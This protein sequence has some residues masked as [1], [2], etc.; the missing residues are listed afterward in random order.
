MKVGSVFIYLALRQM[1][2]GR[3]LFALYEL[4]EEAAPL[5]DERLL[6]RI[7]KAIARAEK[8]LEFEM[9]WSTART[10]TSTKR[11]KA[12]LI[13]AK[14]DQQIGALKSLARLM[15][16]GDEG[17]EV[18]ALAGEFLQAN[19]PDG[20]AAIVQ[21]SFELQLATVDGML[22]RFRGEYRRHVEAL[23]AGPLVDR[24][25]RLNDELRQELRHHKSTTITFDQVR[26]SREETHEE[27]G[28]VVVTILATYPD[29]SEEGTRQRED[30]LAPINRQQAFVVEAHRRRRRPLDVDP[31]T[32]IEVEPTVEDEVLTD[33][34]PVEDVVVV[35]I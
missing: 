3:V 15:T 27:L 20:L 23:N 32:G 24:I 22:R 1:P 25:E 31:R 35:D 29:R 21:Q 6:R 19:F 17:S 16:V 11:G 12:R 34:A 2:T 8:T 4:R 18:V 9:R 33:D 13:D 7:D 28:E 14:L 30:L 10:D 5:G 26:A